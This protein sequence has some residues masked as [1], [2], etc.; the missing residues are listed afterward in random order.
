[1][2]LESNHKDLNMVTEE[3]VGF[4]NLYNVNVKVQLSNLEK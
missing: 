4:N 3:T 2:N 1:M